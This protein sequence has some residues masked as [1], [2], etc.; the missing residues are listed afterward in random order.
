MDKI[1]PVV[2]LFFFISGSFIVAFN[3]VLA[4]GLV[5]DS[6]N[7]KASMSQTR[8]GLGV[9]AVDGKIYA[10]GGFTRS[11]YLGINE[12]YDPVTD[13]WTSLSSMPTPRNNFAIAAYD[14]KIYCVGGITPKNGGGWYRCG[15]NEVYD[16]DADSWS[17]MASF[18]VNESG[19][20]AYVLEAHVVDGKIFVIMACDLYMYDPNT[21][22]WTKKTSMPTARPTSKF[23]FVLSVTDDMADKI[24]VVGDFPVTGSYVEKIMIYDTKT[25]VWR[26]GTNPPVEKIFGVVGVTSGV[27]APQ[28]V[29]VLGTGTNYNYVYDPETDVWSTAQAM[30]TARYSFGVAVVDDILYAIGGGA[31]HTYIDF[32]SINEQ[33]I[34]NDYNTTSSTASP[35]SFKPT[36]SPPTPELFDTPFKHT[37][38]YPVVVVL[39]I[40]VVTAT[41]GL[42]FSSKK[43]NLVH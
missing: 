42:V 9:V 18:P 27:Y 10:I 3:L 7:K 37:L 33:Y 5:E 14:G 16:V 11:G 25:D 8:F 4:S 41:V 12:R 32:L 38:T 43:R 26:E 1:I 39:V 22:V 31:A 15:I 2:F 6:W 28:R 19:L 24:V 36:T 35:E 20:Q 23:S 40:M 34:P 17:T 21:D 13:T 29:Y 30:P